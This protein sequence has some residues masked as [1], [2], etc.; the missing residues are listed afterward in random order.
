MFE[1]FFEICDNFW[2]TVFIVQL[3]VKY[4]QEGIKKKILNIQK[5]FK[6]RKQNA[7]PK[8]TFFKKELCSQDTYGIQNFRIDFDTPSLK[9]SSL[10]TYVFWL[11][12]KKGS[13]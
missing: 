2:T 6:I 11:K 7:I 10:F 8:G 13:K 4:C 9:V 3:P 5:E 1:P 12:S